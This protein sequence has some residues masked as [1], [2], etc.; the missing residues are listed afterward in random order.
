[1][2]K[3][4][5]KGTRIKRLPTAKGGNFGVECLTLAKRLTHPRCQSRLHLFNG[6]RFPLTNAEA[7]ADRQR[8]RHGSHH[9]G[10]D[11]IIGVWIRV[12]IVEMGDRHQARFGSKM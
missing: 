9:R 11:T 3:I 12:I 5:K 4:A 8:R 6:R 1:M 7:E 2:K 10:G